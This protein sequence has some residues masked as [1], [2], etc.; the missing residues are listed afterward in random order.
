MEIACLEMNN[1]L[2]AMLFNSNDLVGL[3]K[4]MKKQF[5][6][7]KRTQISDNFVRP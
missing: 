5:K 6:K 1:T 7:F 2:T 3:D 4:I